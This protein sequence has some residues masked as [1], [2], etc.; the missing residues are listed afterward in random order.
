MGNMFL[1]KICFFCDINKKPVAGHCTQIT[2]G[3]GGDRFFFTQSTKL[4][5]KVKIE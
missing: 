2:T 4:G 5:G 1:I 3:N